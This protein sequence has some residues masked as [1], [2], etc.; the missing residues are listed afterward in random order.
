MFYQVDHKA[1]P[2]RMKAKNGDENIF[3]VKIRKFN[4]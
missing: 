2:S 3:S 4:Q 1:S